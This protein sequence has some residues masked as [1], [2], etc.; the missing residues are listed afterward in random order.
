M[1]T[2]Q[3]RAKVAVPMPFKQNSKMVSSCA[4]ETARTSFFLT[5]G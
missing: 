3:V 4:P 2:Q 1:G 5:P